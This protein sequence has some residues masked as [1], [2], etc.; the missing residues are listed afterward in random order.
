[1]S[2]VRALADRLLPSAVVYR[3]WFWKYTIVWQKRNA[4][5]LSA[6]AEC[7]EKSISNADI[8]K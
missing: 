5:Q 1:M 6:A 3:H 4:A 8:H 7:L 2:H